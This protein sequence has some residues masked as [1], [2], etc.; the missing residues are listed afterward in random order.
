MGYFS[1]TC[2]L[3]GLA[4]PGGIPIRVLLLN[5]SS[6]GEGWSLRTPPAAYNDYGGIKNI[7]PQ[8]ADICDLWRQ[9]LD[10]D[11]VEVG[12]GDNTCHDV[13]ARKRMSFDDL[14]EAL[15]EDRVR[16]RQDTKHFWRPL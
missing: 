5:M 9:A 13:P 6:Y 11:L 16:V 4:I 1:A 2:A 10:V 12:M 7:D 3:S 8:D 14:C 15:S